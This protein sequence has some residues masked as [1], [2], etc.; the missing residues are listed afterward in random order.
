M[1]CTDD[2]QTAPFHLH[3]KQRYGNKIWISRPNK[4]ILDEY[5]LGWQE[6]L[7]NFRCA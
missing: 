4:V 6:G 5:M 1:Y 2:I 3:E 7:W